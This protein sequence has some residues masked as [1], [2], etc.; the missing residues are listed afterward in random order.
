M[1]VKSLSRVQ[2][3]AIPWTA[4][5]QAPPSVGFS[6]QEYWSGVP[7]PSPFNSLADGNVQPNRR[8]EGKGVKSYQT[9]WSS[10]QNVA[11]WIFSPSFKNFQ[12]ML[13]SRRYIQGPHLEPTPSFHPHHPPPLVHPCKSSPFLASVHRVPCP[14]IWASPSSAYSSETSCFS[15][16]SFPNAHSPWPPAPL[17]SFTSHLTCMVTY[18]NHL[19]TKLFYFPTRM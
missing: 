7:L 15:V 11:F 16:K 8:P 2:L 13:A 12:H 5:Y 1:R 6:K 14:A 10:S 9:C 17:S 4:A 18:I 3:L 19:L